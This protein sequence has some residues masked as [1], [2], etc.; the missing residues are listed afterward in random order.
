VPSVEQPA[1]AVPSTTAAATYDDTYHDAT[2]ENNGTV[3]AQANDAY[4]DD[5]DDIQIDLGNNGSA[6]A[7]PDTPTNYS[8]PVPAPPT[9]GPN[10]KEDG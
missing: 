7:Q 5:D 6:I 2:A 4:E 8:T 3:D 10:T 9:R 1:A